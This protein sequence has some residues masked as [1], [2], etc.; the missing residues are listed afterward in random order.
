LTNDYGGFQVFKA[1]TMDGIIDVKIDVEGV[2][3]FN[4]NT[5][6]YAGSVSRTLISRYSTPRWVTSL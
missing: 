2:A 5:V 1:C 6:F 3:N 4:N